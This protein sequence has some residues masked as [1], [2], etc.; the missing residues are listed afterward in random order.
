[1]AYA[2]SAVGLSRGGETEAR[3][4]LL[5]ARSLPE[6]QFERRAVCAAAAAELAR[7]QRDSELVKEAVELVRGP[8]GSDSPPLTLDQA[9]QVLQ[10]EKAEPAVTRPGRRAPDYRGIVGAQ[11]PCPKCRRARGEAVDPFDDDVDFDEEAFGIPPDMPPEIARMLFEETKDAVRRGES[12]D[13]F[14]A[15]LTGRGLP[16]R[17]RK[18]GRRT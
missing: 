14:M 5:R 6:R 3:F 9:R 18:K 11:C 17:K 12:L 16:R 10:T 8:Y 1:M 13:E 4:L 7:H 2:V 15:R